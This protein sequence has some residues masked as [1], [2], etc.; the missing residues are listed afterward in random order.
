M[1]ALLGR[2]TFLRFESHGEQLFI[3]KMTIFFFEVKKNFD[4]F[5]W[6][7]FATNKIWKKKFFALPLSV[8]RWTSIFQG[9]DIVL[10]LNRAC[11]G[12][13]LPFFMKYLACSTP[14]EFTIIFMRVFTLCTSGGV[15]ERGSTT[16]GWTNQKRL[17]NFGGV[18]PSLRLNRG[19]LIAMFFTSL[20]VWVLQ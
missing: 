19:R 20:T 10:A 5:N 4:F 11:F 8:T 7:I 9:V 18:V 17:R 13:V 14:C 3:I 12:C 2:K 6:H 15:T 16:T 1:V